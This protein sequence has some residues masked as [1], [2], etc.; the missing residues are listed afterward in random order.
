MNPMGLI[1]AFAGFLTLYIGVKGSQAK[2]VQAFSGKTA[3]T[4]AKVTVA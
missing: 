2:V 3:S 4:A 1:I